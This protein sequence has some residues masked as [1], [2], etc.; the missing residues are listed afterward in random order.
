V[1]EEQCKEALDLLDDMRHYRA[2]LMENKDRNSFSLS[3][4]TGLGRSHVAVHVPWS[5]VCSLICERISGIQ[6]DLDRLGVEY[7]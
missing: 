5:M 6:R 3:V 4:D 2:A 7:H 1:T